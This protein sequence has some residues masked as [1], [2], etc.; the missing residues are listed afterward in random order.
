MMRHLSVP[1]TDT[2]LWI[3]YL[4]KRDWLASSVAI[5]D[6]G[7]RRGIPLN[8]SAP[9]EIEGLPVV[10]LEPK[11][12]GPK[13]WTD[14]L[15]PE[16]FERH[17]TFWPTSNDQLGDLVIL[18]IPDEVKAFKNEIGNAILTHSERARIICEDKGVKGEFRVRDL[19]IIASRDGSTTTRTQVKEHSKKL[20]I[21]PAK[22]YYSPR[23]GTERL[24]TY[25]EGANL[26]KRLS[27]Q[28]V[29]CDPYA[30]VGPNLSL[31]DKEDFVK[32]II[33]SDLNPEAVELLKL[34][35]SSESIICCK[36]ARELAKE[37]QNKADLLLV[38]LPHDSIDHLPSLL[39]LLARGHEVMIRGWAIINKDQITE[40]ETKIEAI[41]QDH[42]IIEL[43]IIPIKSY[44][45]QDEVIR[46]QI[47]MIFNDR[48]PIY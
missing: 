11:L 34:N 28:I 31:F 45:P 12:P 44:S 3:E 35:L 39:G 17:S 27:R 7:I 33:A 30:G 22:A 16:L 29:I 24:N 21:D 42:D 8:H 46:F 40:V 10:D 32:L 47:R 23:L 4:S 9:D 6:L 15:S 1:R 14:R 19:Q 13:H 48:T 36:D 41:I 2:S 37:H 20:W 5:Q 26:A 25:E 43:N 38:N 18:K